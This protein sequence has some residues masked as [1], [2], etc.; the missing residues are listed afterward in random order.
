[1][2][3]S[4][5]PASLLPLLSR[6]SAASPAS[7]LPSLRPTQPHDATLHPTIEAL[8]SPPSLRAMLHLLNDDLSSA[9]EIAQSDE[10]N[11]SSDLIHSILHRREADYWNSK[12][13]LDQFRHPILPVV[14]EKQDYAEVR[15]SAKRFVDEVEA[16]VGGKGRGGA[17]TACGAQKKMEELKRWQWRELS[18][19]AQ[20][21]LQECGLKA[22]GLEGGVAATAATAPA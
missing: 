2:A 12:W 10:G 16:L 17:T 19:L 11:P 9:H 15:R 21:V 13:W 1:M 3:A 6:G 4:A 8:S 22:E 7:S 18:L 5:L 20:H 14:Y